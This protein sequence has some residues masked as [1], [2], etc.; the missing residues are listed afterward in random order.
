MIISYLVEKKYASL[1]LS[2]YNS[3]CDDKVN[4]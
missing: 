2:Y 3:T 1:W 4:N